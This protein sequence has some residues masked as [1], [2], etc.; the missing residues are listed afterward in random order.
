MVGVPAGVAAVRQAQTGPAKN[1][2]QEGA[3]V[4]RR[5]GGALHLRAHCGP[6]GGA[7]D[8]DGVGADLW[9]GNDYGG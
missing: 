4:G 2:H 9:V 5:G 3:G 1:P 8:C 6:A 7:G